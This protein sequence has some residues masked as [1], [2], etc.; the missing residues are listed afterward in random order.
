MDGIF[1]IL[2]NVVF[3]IICVIPLVYAIIFFKFKKSL[4]DVYVFVIFLFYSIENIIIFI[5]EINLWFRGVYNNSFMLNPASRTLIFFVVL[6]SFTS[7]SIETI[8]KKAHNP[9]KY[10]FYIIL[11]VLFIFQLFVPLL[12]NSALKI[13]IYYTP[14]QLYLILLNIYVLKT[15]NKDREKL[16]VDS[17]KTSKNLAIAIILINIMIIIEDYIVIFNFDQYGPEKIVMFNRS[18]S[19]NLLT[20]VLAF[21][22]TISYSKSLQFL[23][24]NIDVKDYS[25]DVILGEEEATPPKDNITKLD[26]SKLKSSIVEPS[27]NIHNFAKLH[28]ITQ[29]E[30]E[31]LTLILNGMN[32]NKI[33][34]TLYISPGTVKAHKHNVYYKLNVSNSTELKEMYEDYLKT[35]N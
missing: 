23:L 25:V 28:E 27:N 30:E 21:F 35:L 13:F 29:R 8:D 4:H 9:A 16:P 31:I 26:M 22:V 3:H 1:S 6:F 17:Y 20:V 15:I 5:T 33:S 2:Y 12:P 14:C 10:I 18:F 34:E 32:N 11:G 19:E 24:K 7:I